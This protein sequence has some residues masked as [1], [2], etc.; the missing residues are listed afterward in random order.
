MMMTVEKVKSRIYLDD[1]VD[2]DTFILNESLPITSS[3]D[4][5]NSTNTPFS[6][7]SILKVLLTTTSEVNNESVAFTLSQTT[8]SVVSDSSLIDQLNS[9]R[10]SEVLSRIKQCD[11]NM[12]LNEMCEIYSID[13]DT[14]SL[15]HQSNIEF[16]SLKHLSD[17]LV[18]RMTVE[19]LKK[20]CPTAHWCL[21]N[22]TQDDIRFTTDVIR[23][24]GRSFCSLDQ[25]Y[26]RLIIHMNSCPLL[27]NKV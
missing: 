11:P 25:C 2:T 13:N 24:R 20:F 1:F 3:I 9:Y 6:S 15:K 18:D 8:A 16:Q 26:H 10:N 12:K 7:S 19:K 14:K 17:S 22:L 4:I 5:A 27:A 23:Q 21:G